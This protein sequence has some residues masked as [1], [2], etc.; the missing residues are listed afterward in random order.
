MELGWRRKGGRPEIKCWACTRTTSMDTIMI[1]RYVNGIR[2]VLHC[3]QV[4]IRSVLGRNLAQYTW[5]QHAKTRQVFATHMGKRVYLQDIIKGEKGPWVHVNGDPWDFREENL[6]KTTVRTVKRTESSSRG[7]GICYIDSRKN[8]KAWKTT[9]AGKFIGYF[10]TEEEAMKARLKALMA[11]S[12]MIKF[13]PEGTDPDGPTGMKDR[14]VYIADGGRPDAYLDLD[15]VEATPVA[16]YPFTYGSE[17][18]KH[19]DYWKAIPPPDTI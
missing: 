3:A 7:V 8:G 16:Q 18:I 2:T 1:W 14:S 19:T 6:I 12:P 11:S 4:S 10:K 17:P 15:D 9:L 13:V 5:Y